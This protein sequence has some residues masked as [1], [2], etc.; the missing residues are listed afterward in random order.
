MAGSALAAA[1]HVFLTR[2][3]VPCCTLL[4]RL[5]LMDLLSSYVGR[6]RCLSDRNHH[7]QT[8]RTT[9]RPEYQLNKSQEL[10]TAS[11]AGDEGPLQTGAD[12][13]IGELG[14]EGYTSS[15]V[16]SISCAI[17]SIWSTC[18]STSSSSRRFAAP[19][20]GAFTATN[21]LLRS[22]RSAWG[23]PGPGHQEE[24]EGPGLPLGSPFCL[25]GTHFFPTW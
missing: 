8:T 4:P 21:L 10:T 23:R 6:A 25:L 22:G 3:S 11:A 5:D 13:P 15:C 20:I 12:Q 19:A 2:S 9:I 7:G 14:A 1:T 17:A 18:A 24:G 16:A